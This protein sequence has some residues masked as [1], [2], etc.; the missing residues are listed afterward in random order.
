MTNN[1][2]DPKSPRCWWFI[3]NIGMKTGF[4]GKRVPQNMINGI[5]VSPELAIGAAAGTLLVA[6]IICVLQ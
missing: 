1:Y 3:A 5:E 6:A 2:E 4:D